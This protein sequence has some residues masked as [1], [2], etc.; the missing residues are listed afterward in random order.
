MSFNT[1]SHFYS[2]HLLNLQADGWKE[3]KGNKCTVH[4]LLGVT[5]DTVAGTHGAGDSRPLGQDLCP[6]P[7]PTW[8][9]LMGSHV[10]VR[11]SKACTLST[12]SHEHL[13]LKPFWEE[14]DS[15]RGCWAHPA[16]SKH[17][18]ARTLDPDPPAHSIT[19]FSKPGFI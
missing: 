5:A 1:E 7:T 8:T 4:V 13:G 15:Q 16:S 18:S 12:V 2:E 17:C 14:C 10:S 3:R 11:W 19:T 6:A 9:T